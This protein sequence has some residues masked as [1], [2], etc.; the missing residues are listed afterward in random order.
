MK[1]NMQALEKYFGYLDNLRESGVTNMYGAS[2][3]LEE[4]FSLDR[5][6][7]SAI[8]GQWIKTFDPAKTP[9][10]RARL[11]KGNKSTQG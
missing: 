10:E 4:V 3:Y 8:L 6:K 9:T 1:T 7:A 2:I 11:V 5:K